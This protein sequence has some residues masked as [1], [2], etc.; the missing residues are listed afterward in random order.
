MQITYPSA[1]EI[2]AWEALGNQAWSWKD[3]EPY[4]RRSQTFIRPSGDVSALLG[5]YHYDPSKYGDAGPIKISF[6]KTCSELHRA[7]LEAFEAREH[8]MH[9]DP[10]SGDAMG[11]FTN[12]ASVDPDSMNRSYSTSA[13]YHTNS[14]RSNL[15]VRTG[16]HVQKI[17]LDS[18]QSTTGK[19]LADR[20]AFIREGREYV[21]KV[22]LVRLN[23]PITSNP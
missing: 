3:L 19:I 4:Y 6:Y 7:W 11:G 8:R 23:D 12:P 18:S 2:D 14:A 20:V 10:L 21:A 17:H 16:A 22:R 15:F 5:T 13:Y 9:G 1:A